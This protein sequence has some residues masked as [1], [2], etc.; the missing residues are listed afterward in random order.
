MAAQLLALPALAKALAFAKGITGLGGAVKGGSAT[1]AALGKGQ[2]ARMA[3]KKF[4]GDALAKAGTMVPKSVGEATKMVVGKDLY[5][6]KGDLLF[7]LA[8]DA[9]FGVMG[10][11]MTPGDLGDK[12]IAGGTQFLGGGLTGIA[13]G[14]G[15]RALGMGTRAADMAD[16]VGSVGGD[17]L[18]MAVG[19][20]IL[21]AKGGGMTPMEQQMMEQDALYRAQLEQEFLQKYGFNPAVDPVMA[22]NGLV[23]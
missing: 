13:A 12:V 17:F 14:R 18:G 22:A 7:R 6:N 15:A 5:N 21:R 4:A 16:M 2:A 10:G 3:A 1:L 19:D 20:Q 9:V 11:V 8:P 23:A